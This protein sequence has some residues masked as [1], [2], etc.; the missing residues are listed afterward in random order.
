MILKVDQKF[1]A[2]LEKIYGYATAAGRAPPPLQVP[3]TSELYRLDPRL[4]W[5]K[6][7]GI[8]LIPTL[9]L[10]Q[11]AELIVYT[12]MAKLCVYVC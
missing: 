6:M 5:R 9:I 10:A 2:P 4:N 8:S 11:Q 7:T 3:L 1:Q 12:T